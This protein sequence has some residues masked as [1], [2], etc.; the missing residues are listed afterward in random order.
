MRPTL[1]VADYV[2]R[3][4]VQESILDGRGWRSFTAIEVP[5]FEGF[6]SGERPGAGNGNEF[7]AARQKSSQQNWL[8]LREKKGV[9]SL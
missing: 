2:R 5:E 6:S 9:T 3:V 7:D 4:T 8:T 1:H